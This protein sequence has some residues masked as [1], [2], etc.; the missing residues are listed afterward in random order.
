MSVKDQLCEAFCDTLTVSSVPAGLAI[1]TQYEGLGG[2]PIGVYV[3]GPSPQ[4]LYHIQDDGISVPTLE[5]LGADISNKMRREAFNELLNTYGVTYDEETAELKTASVSQAAVAPLVMRFLAFMLRLQDLALMAAER[6]A[7][8]FREDALRTIS[9]LVDGRAALRENFV[10]APSLSEFPADLGII[11]DGKPPV[12]L[13]W[14]VSESK[15]YEALL[16]QAYAQS[17]G[18]P[19]FVATLIESQTTVSQ[20]MRQRAAN[21]LDASPF[22]RGDEAQACARLV[23][24]VI[25]SVAAPGSPTKQ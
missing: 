3:I 15:V 8:T 22:Y 18:I 12:A 25:G 13:F 5:S 24:P 21:H 4:G 1:G 16:L 23:R 2:D 9:A 10:V 17:A 20:K 14:G 19:C 6:A 7:S 11:A